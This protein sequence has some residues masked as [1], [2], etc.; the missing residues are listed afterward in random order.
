[1]YSNVTFNVAQ[2]AKVASSFMYTWGQRFIESRVLKPVF[3]LIYIFFFI[4]ECS[5]SVT[6]CLFSFIIDEM[7]TRGQWSD[8]LAWRTG[9]FCDHQCAVS[10]DQKCTVKV[11][12]LSPVSPVFINAFM[13]LHAQLRLICFKER[14]R[15]S[16]NI[17]DFVS[18]G[19]VERCCRPGDFTSWYNEAALCWHKIDMPFKKAGPLLQM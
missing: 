10:A 2:T 8:G 13:Q 19:R 7:Q 17:I 16:L 4:C 12:Q 1:M 18:M 6:L 5:S 14:G 3:Y 9:C 11:L 15:L